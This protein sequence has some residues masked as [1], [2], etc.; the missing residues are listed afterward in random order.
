[1]FQNTKRTGSQNIPTVVKKKAGKSAI[2]ILD[3]RLKI[4]VQ[5]KLLQTSATVA[6]VVQQK[7]S[8]TGLP[9]K[10]KQGVENLSGLSM[11]DVKVH[12]NSAKPA[13]L[14][15]H[16]FAQGT[17]IHIAP[18]QEKHLPHEAWHVVQQKQG[19][20]KPVM[21]MKGHVNINDDKQLEKE[22]DVMGEKAMSAASK[23]GRE[24]KSA[25][26]NDTVL[27]GKFFRMQ[28]PLRPSDT[29][30]PEKTEPQSQPQAIPVLA[31]EESVVQE[32]LQ[33]VFVKKNKIKMDALKRFIKKLA[34][35]PAIFIYSQDNLEQILQWHFDKDGKSIFAEKGTDLAA[36][37]KIN[38]LAGLMQIKMSLL[39]LPRGINSGIVNGVN[40]LMNQMIRLV[41]MRQYNESEYTLQVGI[42]LLKSTCSHLSSAGSRYIWR[43]F[44]ILSQLGPLS[45]ALMMTAATDGNR[46]Q[47]AICQ[48]EIKNYLRFI[49]QLMA[50]NPDGPTVVAHRGAGPTNRTM[51]GLIQEGDNRRRKRPAENSP[52]AFRH[53]LSFAAFG[54][55]DGV[56]C[57]VFLSKDKVPILSHEANVKEQLTKAQ[58]VIHNKLSE[59]DEVHDLTM[60][61]LTMISRTEVPDSRFMTLE[62]LLMMTVGVAHYYY[63][64]TGKA[65]RVEVEMKGSKH[66]PELGDIV[67]KTI[68]QFEKKVAGLPIEIVLFNGNADEVK[69]FANKRNTKTALGAMYTGLGVKTEDLRAGKF[70][71]EYIDELRY[72]FTSEFSA[73]DVDKSDLAFANRYLDDF[74]TT[75]VFGQ[76]FAPKDVVA[77]EYQPSQPLMYGSKADK[78]P[79]DPG[80]DM[81]IQAALERYASDPKNLEKIKKLHILTDYPMKARW[82]KDGIMSAS[83]IA[84]DKTSIKK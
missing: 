57:D 25:G 76:E 72:Q 45:Y 83:K 14:N 70:E 82:I 19:R 78:R 20:V 9:N 66:S 33:T 17:N 44:D 54:Q 75:L 21:Q 73:H 79:L 65:F 81:A 16:A 5:R 56:E 55:L 6:N 8:T 74:I 46:K 31:D 67:A 48:Q 47:M 28:V 24:L 36:W 53:A 49:R 37:R 12:V 52:H 29:P 51:G 7:N 64:S 32:S 35:G 63:E 10:L 39:K 13:Q 58:H 30:A 60:A 23:H 4:S 59:K 26:Q 43:L 62:E 22:A 69:G 50:T 18:G 71:K 2:G 15:A 77:E 42:A 1:M 40:A 80:F 11:D 61:E 34:E 84:L 3:N 68:S 38:R 41:R 27:Q